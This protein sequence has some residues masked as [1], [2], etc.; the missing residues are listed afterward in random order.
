M[1][2]NDYKEPMV[3]RISFADSRVPEF[4]EVRYK[5]WILY[6]ENNLYPDYLLYLYNKSSKH[7]AI[8]NAKSKYIFGNGLVSKSMPLTAE[9]TK[10]SPVVNRKGET[11]NDIV[12]KS[13][14]DVEIH[15][16]FRWQI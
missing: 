11:L 12:K 1:D 16:G 4:K 14:K 15:G 10:F 9:G 3:M 13:I 5:E 2:N 7:G 6:G 8:I